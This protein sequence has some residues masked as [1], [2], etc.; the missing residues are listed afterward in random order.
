MRPRGRGG[1]LP[2]RRRTA[3]RRGPGV[4]RVRVRPRQ[5]PDRRHA[6]SAGPLGFEVGVVLAALLAGSALASV[7]LARYGDRIGRRR[8][9]P[10]APARRHGRRRHGVRA[11]RLAAGARPRGPHR[12][13][14]TD[15]V[16]SGPFTSLEQAMLPHA[17]GTATR[18]GSSATYNTVATLAGSLGALLRRP[19]LVHARPRAGSSPIRSRPRAALPVCT[20]AS[21]RRSSAATSHGGR[22]P[23]APPLTRDRRAGSPALFALDSFGGGFVPQTFIAYLFTR[24]YGASAQTLGIVFFA[25]GAAP[26]ALLPGGRAASPTGSACCERWSSRTCPRTC[27]SQRSRS[28]RTCR[29][30][31]RCCSPAS[32]SRRWTCRRGRRYVVAVVDPSE[33]TAAAAYT[34][35]ARYVTRPIAPLVAG[36]APASGHSARRSLIAGVLKSVYDLGFYALFRKR[37][38]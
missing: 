25:I 20:A 8:T 34:N 37:L 33:R 21:R 14:S 28:R 15:V 27:C 35:T 10:A 26:G 5:R 18:L 29:P 31:S 36:V 9:L 24:K 11:D 30:R 2:E 19:A 16:E 6:G 38:V 4:S 12:H 23:A 3:H 22:P 13:V 7:A 32:R 1:T 17:A